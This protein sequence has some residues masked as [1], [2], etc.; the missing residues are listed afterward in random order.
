MIAMMA[1]KQFFNI[2]MMIY[3]ELMFLGEISK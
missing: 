1:G 3:S 2:Q